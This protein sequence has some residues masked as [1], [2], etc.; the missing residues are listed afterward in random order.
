MRNPEPIEPRRFGES[1]RRLRFLDG[2][3]CR[4]PG[5]T[6]SYP[7]SVLCQC[8]VPLVL[9]CLSRCCGPNDRCAGK[10]GRAAR[11][12][13][14]G[15]S[16]MTTPFPWA[17]RHVEPAMLPSGVH[18]SLREARSDREVDAPLLHAGSPSI[19]PPYA[20]GSSVMHR[21]ALIA[22]GLIESRSMSRLDRLMQRPMRHNPRRCPSP[23]SAPEGTAR[24]Q[25][26]LAGCICSRPK[27]RADTA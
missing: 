12:P 10:T 4:A 15:M 6:P 13:D 8:R 9:S 27:T 24:T 17:W 5:E 11:P 26:T 21:R 18:W 23:A 22:L 19:I 25:H 16:P 20:A 7:K 14:H 2:G 1:R 3:E